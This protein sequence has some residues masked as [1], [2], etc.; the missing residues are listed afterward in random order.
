MAEY[1]IKFS[2]PFLVGEELN[3]ISQCLSSGQ[4]SGDGNFTRACEDV[5]SEISETKETL[6][7]T[8]CTDALEMALLLCDLD[9]GDEVLIPSYNFSSA[10]AVALS[11]GLVPV[12]VDIDP[13]NLNLDPNLIEPAITKNT[14]GIIPIHYGGVPAE[15]ESIN[16]LATKN[17]L[18]V[19]E[20]NAHS[21]GSSING[22]PLGSLSDISTL[23]FHSTKNVSCGEG[24]A[25][26]TSN[27][28]F[29]DRAHILREK[30]T[31]RRSFIDG[32]VDKYTWVDMGG[33]FLPCEYTAAY[34]LAQLES[35]KEI[36]QKRIQIWN[37]Y[38]EHLDD[39]AEVN[40]VRLAPFPPLN[41]NYSGHIFW[42]IFDE[43]QTRDE[44]IDWMNRN[45][46]Q[47]TTHYRSLNSA[48]ASDKFQLS[49]SLTPVSD[50]TAN[51]LV[52]LPLHGNLTSEQVL[53]VCSIIREFE[54]KL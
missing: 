47:V 46:I 13:V 48:P 29:I 26:Q 10:P 24:G 19:I 17:E 12:F 20:D 34:L 35:Y 44:F 11:L 25:L 2:E 4:I 28:E 39:W 30:G 54:K 33:S 50:A 37:T 9:P 16:E 52:R 23:S 8:S 41:V 27:D 42:L 43:P 22:K 51:Q 32:H 21:L 53:H 1:Q 31:N 3:Y 40:R 49:K 15:I 5:L 45:N 38:R 36:Q 18:I 6:L 7:T 14:R